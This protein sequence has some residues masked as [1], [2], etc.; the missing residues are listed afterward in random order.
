M[1]METI[2]SI[3][4]PF[5]VKASCDIQGKQREATKVVLW[6]GEVL[7]SL[8][9]QK[10]EHPGVLSFMG[11]ARKP[12]RFPAKQLGISVQKNIILSTPLQSN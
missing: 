6:T 11:K 5:A 9:E 4:L 3:F 10:E 2:A 8:L 12:L 1:I 7:V